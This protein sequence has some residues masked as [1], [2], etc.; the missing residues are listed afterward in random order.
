MYLFYKLLIVTVITLLVEDRLCTWFYGLKVRIFFLN[1][2]IP[3]LT[4]YLVTLQG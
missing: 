1:Y 2:G 3:D 4:S